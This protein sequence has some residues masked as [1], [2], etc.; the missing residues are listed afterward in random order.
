[1]ASHQTPLA[2]ITPPRMATK[3]EP[4][5]GTPDRAT[6]AAS[7]LSPPQKAAIIV[8]FLLSNGMELPL[9]D[10]PASVQAALTEQIGQMRLVDRA[11]LNQ[12]IEE[13]AGLLESVGLTFPSGIEAALSAMNDHISSEAALRLR[14]MASSTASGDP[15][16]RIKALSSTGLVGA[17][18]NE[19]TEVA[20]VVLSKL[21]PSRA[22]EILGLLPGNHA[23]RIAFAV[24]QTENTDPRTVQRIGRAILSRVDSAPS[25]AFT[26]KPEDRVGAIL[27]VSSATTRERVLRGLEEEDTAFAAG[28][29]RTIFTYGHIP[30][31]IAPRD[32]P[33]IIRVIDQPT[34]VTAMKF[35]EEREEAA[36]NDFLLENLP[37][38]LGQTIRD[39]L[40]ERTPVREKDGEA[41]MAEIMDSIRQLE[42]MGELELIDLEESVE[43]T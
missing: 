24:S 38:R 9:S 36:T 18:E 40:T 8:R 6:G 30:A 35:N 31:R 42:G 7:F 11:T 43:K 2:R 28:V 20:A 12:V 5:A 22:A 41:A 33:K 14:R 13:F 21:P 3:R 32:V 26:H 16:E 4:H 25:R 15:W 37:Q 1:M 29:R 39:E 19:A 17:L 34:L 27:N 10:L 23:R